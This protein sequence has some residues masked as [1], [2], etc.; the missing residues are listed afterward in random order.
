MRAP[1]GGTAVFTYRLLEDFGSFF[2]PEDGVPLRAREFDPHGKGG[3]WTLTQMG[4][5][6]RLKTC[7]TAD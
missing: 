6:G 4:A 5:L 7:D 1:V 3:Y 2:L